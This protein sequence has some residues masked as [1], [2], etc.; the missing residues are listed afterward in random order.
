MTILENLFEMHLNDTL[1]LLYIDSNFLNG[2]IDESE[3]VKF[4]ELLYIIENDYDIDFGLIYRLYNK[5]YDFNFEELIK[6][7]HNLD[8]L[9]ADM[10][11]DVL[12]LI[13]HLYI[14]SLIYCV[15]QMA[16]RQ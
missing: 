11:K 16:C 14:W 13:K 3:R 7:I 8:F 2:Y 5:I 6:L 12:I 1:H 4:I 10:I 9:Q 15:F